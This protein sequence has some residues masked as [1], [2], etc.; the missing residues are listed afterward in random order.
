VT[1]SKGVAGGGTGTWA[2]YNNDGYLDFYSTS[3]QKL[4]KNNGPPDF[5]FADVTVEAGELTDPYP[6]TA[7]GWGDYDRDG[8]V[9]LY[10]GNG[11]DWNDG[12]PI[13]YPNY[14][15]INN[16]DGTFRNGT[17]EVGVDD[18][19][20]ERY[21][22]SVSWVD[23]NNDGWLDIYVGN[24]RQQMNFLYE[25]QGD[26]TF[27]DV[28]LAKGVA[29]GPPGTEGN[30]DP[31][32]RAG[33]TVSTSWGDYDND[34][35]FDLWVTNLNHKDARRS[36]DS[37]LYHNDGPPDYT[38]TNMRAESGI[39]L[40]TTT[41][42]DGDEL[43]VGSAWG[44]YNNDGYLDLYLPQIYD[45]DYAYSFLY[46][47]NGD[48]TFTD[49]TD[50]AGVRVWNTYAGVWADYNQD[51]WLDLLTA[52]SDS[53]GNSDPSYL[54]LYRNNVSGDLNNWF[55]VS[56]DA[57]VSGENP[58]AIGSRV[59]IDAGGMI[60]IREVEGG[61]G[62][63][64]SQNSFTLAFGLGDNAGPVDVTIHWYMSG[65]NQMEVGY[66]VNQ[67]VDITWN[68][69]HD[70]G[71]GSLT[72][73]TPYPIMGD[74]MT[75]STEVTNLGETDLAK[76]SISFFDGPS[77]SGIFLGS[78]TLE[79]PPEPGQ[80]MSIQFPWDT[81]GISGDHS[82]FA[83]L[84]DGIVLDVDSGN[85]E[86]SLSVSIRTINE[87]P[88]AHLAVSPSVIYKTDVVTLDASGSTD[89][90]SV[91]KYRFH[92]GTG[93]DSGWIDDST[94]TTSYD[95][96]GDY[97]VSVEARDSDG[98]SSQAP[99][100]V[101]IHIRNLPVAGLFVSPLTAYI[102]E[103]VTFDASSSFDEDGDVETYRFDFDD[104]DQTMGPDA[105]VQHSYVSLGEYV[106]SLAVVDDSGDISE[107]LASETVTVL[108]VPNQIPTATIVS[109]EPTEVIV[110]Q[111]VDF[112]GSASDLDGT[113]V[114]YEWT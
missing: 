49:V 32:N 65:G 12:D 111:M 106:V 53:G 24:Y 89:D 43:F 13:Y 113:I 97:I 75:L 86:V 37:L 11:E 109:I 83:R 44:D 6:T 15:W 21:T 31:Y 114:M 71:L 102:G 63:H 84:D 5:T 80:S 1:S 104:G 50:Q 74:V 69:V 33:H 95:T 87:L 94:L 45:I 34:G 60:Q 26:G 14:F 40:K 28:G 56:L 48:G 39:P 105:I 78:T 30:P 96:G 107:N 103:P 4:F 22:R 81:S 59:T 72:S 88:I 57:G 8:D 20:D 29:D 79:P 66:A 112:R 55:Q 85:D 91:E 18:V 62:P 73:D 58:L 42:P 52:G 9:D 93:L 27:I 98:E 3:P 90:T 47:N 36:D 25:N 35:Y 61:T 82:I 108:E 110:G 38:F 101:P 76:I 92:F 51:G 10:V 19:G 41:F 64:G 2:D 68:L 77:D 46:L 67:K 17:L 16:G 54:H 7:S 23:Y 99:F 70:N 100:V